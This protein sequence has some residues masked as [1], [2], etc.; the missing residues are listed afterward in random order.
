M[1]GYDGRYKDPPVHH[2]YVRV[3]SLNGEKDQDVRGELVSV[4][5]VGAL[6]VSDSE[7]MLTKQVI[8]G[9]WPVPPVPSYGL[10]STTVHE[11]DIKQRKL[12]SG[13]VS[14]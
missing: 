4:A 6:R 13:K 1:D 2:S 11:K 8:L 7:S 5:M 10:H 9:A 12:L 3:K 14:E